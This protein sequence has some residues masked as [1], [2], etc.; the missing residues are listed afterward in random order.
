MSGRTLRRLPVLAHARY[1]SMAAAD[2]TD[3]G[4]DMD[5]SD[6]EGE[7]GGYAGTAVEVWIDAMEKVV[8]EEG[9]QMEKLGGVFEEG[10]V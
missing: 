9:V 8:A 1:V 6:E 10:G 2:N 4:L 7:E 5:Q 3:Y